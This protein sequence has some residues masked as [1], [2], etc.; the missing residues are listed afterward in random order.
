MGAHNYAH[1]ILYFHW[2][3]SVAAKDND[4]MWK[5]ILAC[6]LVNLHGRPDSWMEIDYYIEL[7]KK[8]E[9]RLTR[10]NARRPTPPHKDSGHSTS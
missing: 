4:I 6:G 5:A 7:Q 3:F 1:E 9:D 2:L 10:T 8:Y